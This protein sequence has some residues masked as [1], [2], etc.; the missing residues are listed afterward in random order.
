MGKFSINNEVTANGSGPYTIVD[1]A[2]FDGVDKD[3][4]YISETDSAYLDEDLILANT[5]IEEK[6]I[7]EVTKAAVGPLE[8]F[9]LLYKGDYKLTFEQFSKVIFTL[10]Q[11]KKILFDTEGKVTK[12]TLLDPK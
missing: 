11:D 1:K 5:N 4:Y 3:V 9:A 8:L 6:I 7:I 2:H 10:I 12:K